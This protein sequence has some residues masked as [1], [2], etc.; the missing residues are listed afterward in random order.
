VKTQA[1]R[2][3]NPVKSFPVGLLLATLFTLCPPGFTESTTTDITANGTPVPAPISPT[4]PQPTPTPTAAPSE[5][6]VNTVPSNVPGSATPTSTN[7]S[8]TVGSNGGGSAS[9]PVNAAPTAVD[10]NNL[11]L[12]Q[13]PAAAKIPEKLDIHTLRD[14]RN[15]SGETLKDQLSKA[16]NVFIAHESQDGLF[17]IGDDQLGKFWKLKRNHVPDDRYVR[18][19]SNE[20]VVTVPFTDVQKGVK[21]DLDFYAVRT[22]EGW[23]VQD[24]R[25]GGVGGVPRYYLKGSAIE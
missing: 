25:L 8:A 17:V 23:T 4:T 11:P 19:K 15:V 6:A 13:Q 2:Y 21:V 3:N 20:D 24:V 1:T 16:V 14:E 9:A 18:V 5:P 7:P 22:D 12:S 10:T